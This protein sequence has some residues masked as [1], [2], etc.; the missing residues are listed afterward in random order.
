MAH[1]N[2]G[3]CTK[4]EY[5]IDSKKVGETPW[6]MGACLL[7]YDSTKLTNGNH[8]LTAKAYDA[9]GNVGTSQPVQF[10]VKN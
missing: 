6:S 2:S 10:L 4:V 9:A 5:Y 3:K 1:D 8:L 7:P